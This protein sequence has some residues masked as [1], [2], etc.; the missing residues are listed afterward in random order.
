MFRTQYD[1][2]GISGRD[3]IAI[4]E[5][6]W[7]NQR[8]ECI[9]GDAW[10]QFTPDY[11]N[12]ESPFGNIG[13]LAEGM[14][15]T[16]SFKMVLQKHKI[17]PKN[18]NKAQ[19]S[20]DKF[21]NKVRF[22]KSV[23]EQQ[24]TV[25]ERIQLNHFL[26][27]TNP[28]TKTTGETTT[29]GIQSVAQSSLGSCSRNS[30]ELST[31]TP[32]KAVGFYSKK[33]SC[34]DMSKR[35]LDL[36]AL[37][38][39]VKTNTEA[40]VKTGTTE[41][42]SGNKSKI[43]K[44]L[45]SSKVSLGFSIF[46]SSNKSS[47]T[48]GKSRMSKITENSKQS[49]GLS[50]LGASRTSHS[51]ASSSGGGG[52]GGSASGS[53]SEDFHRA[54]KGNFN[55][56]VGEK[57]STMWTDMK[58]RDHQHNSLKTPA[59]L[60]RLQEKELLVQTLER[61]HL[62][63]RQENELL[64]AKLAESL[65]YFHRVSA[66]CQ[67]KT[68]EELA[69]V[70]TQMTQAKQRYQ[71]ADQ[72]RIQLHKALEEY[73]AMVEDKENYIAELEEA[74][75]SREQRI[76]LLEARLPHTGIVISSLPL[77]AKGGAMTKP[78][79]NIDDSF[80][81]AEMADDII[82]CLDGPNDVK[83]NND[84]S[85]KSN[86]LD[87]KLGSA[88]AKLENS[89][90]RLM[91]NLFGIEEDLSLTLSEFTKLSSTTGNEN[92]PTS[93]GSPTSKVSTTVTPAMVPNACKT[94]LHL[95]EYMDTMKLPKNNHTSFM[96]SGDGTW[97]ANTVTENALGKGMSS[98]SPVHTIKEGLVSLPE[99]ATSSIS[100]VRTRSMSTTPGRPQ[101][102]KSDCGGTSRSKSLTSRRQS[103]SKSPAAGRPPA[104]RKQLRS[105]V[106]VSNGESHEI[107][108][109]SETTPQTATSEMPPSRRKPKGQAINPSHF[110]GRGSNHS[111][112][113]DKLGR[114]SNHLQT[115]DKL[116]RGSNHS[117]TTDKLGRCSNHAQ[118]TDKLGRGSSHSQTTDKERSPVR[119]KISR[120]SSMHTTEQALRNSGNTNR[121][122][123][124]SNSMGAARSARLSHQR[125]TSVSKA[126]ERV[127]SA[128]LPLPPPTPSSTKASPKASSR[129]KSSPSPTEMNRKAPSRS[130]SDG[131]FDDDFF[132]PPPPP[133]SFYKP[134]PNDSILRKKSDPSPT[135]TNRKAPSR[136]K[137]DGAHDEFF[138]NLVQEERIS[139]AVNH[140]KE[141]SNDDNE[142]TNNQ[143]LA[144]RKITFI[145][146]KT[147]EVR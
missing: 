67:W 124:R 31:C 34:L 51:N 103:R 60:A 104:L 19:P 65:V 32:P 9:D 125:K 82:S 70:T 36:E 55:F 117:Q 144:K 122:I 118:A 126:L 18:N 52:G 61:E 11:S 7:R 139:N 127:C 83:S 39:S 147:I 22:E 44:S 142:V 20:L 135:E 145:P 91:R 107:A 42:T 50:A 3:L 46:S 24:K 54:N 108:T 25:T 74:A 112:A 21:F 56:S 105:V 98:P 58:R 77:P 136:S 94:G 101:R 96:T 111:Q 47:S 72:E 123:G 113:T 100:A 90:D 27:A 2:S 62:A 89:D 4:A 79:V 14:D 141:G 57:F 35:S 97:A 59:E 99:K 137:S 68:I 41:L 84:A 116:G 87:G 92:S 33:D 76:S 128:D 12:G 17:T 49:L 95:E 45:E 71:E 15:P 146:K 106:E 53:G 102:S 86:V 134:S 1:T 40:S 129:K 132:L 29:S 138:S 81:M 115:T 6:S 78:T 30:I 143:G 114:G 110:L 13:F 120:S 140:D 23:D 37:H 10:S 66:L 109:L 85:T 38:A 119:Q 28:T 8:G 5:Q 131:T 93:K 63:A 64:K 121:S 73:E 88:L 43:S 16:K 80:S 130:K 75:V 133:P 48:D 26:K 69:T